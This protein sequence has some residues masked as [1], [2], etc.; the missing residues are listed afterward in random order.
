MGMFVKKKNNDNIKIKN[1]RDKS[2]SNSIGTQV[3]CN[4]IPPY[5]KLKKL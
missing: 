5:Q 1:Y 3:C 2:I 4:F